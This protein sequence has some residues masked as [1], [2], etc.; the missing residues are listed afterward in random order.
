MLELFRLF[1]QATVLKHS[2]LHIK[3]NRPA[4]SHVLVC[5]FT[6]FESSSNCDTVVIEHPDGSKLR[7]IWTNRGDNSPLDRDFRENCCSQPTDQKICQDQAV[8]FAKRSSL[9]KDVQCVTVSA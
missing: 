6:L 1:K 2:T 5:E 8:M 3:R 4:M 9:R 7:P